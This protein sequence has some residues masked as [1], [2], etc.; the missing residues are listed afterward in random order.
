MRH[1]APLIALSLLLPLAAC[2][3]THRDEDNEADEIK[4]PIDQVPPAVRAALQQQAPGAAITS[5][6]K[7]S[8]GG[9][10]IY[11]ADAMIAGQNYEIKVADDGTRVSKKVDNEDDEK[12]EKK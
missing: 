9:K 4:V 11:E 12:S 5:V 2:T 1:I 6:D 8:E 10:T 7:E 3:A